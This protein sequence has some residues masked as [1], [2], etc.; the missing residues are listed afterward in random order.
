MGKENNKVDEKLQIVR[1]YEKEKYAI[2]N[3]R[4]V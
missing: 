2:N 4:K 3:L 1:K